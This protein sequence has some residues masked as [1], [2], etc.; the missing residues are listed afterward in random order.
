MTTVFIKFLTGVIC[1]G[2]LIAGTGALA[3]GTRTDVQGFVAERESATAFFDA[4]SSRLG[5]SVILSQKAARKKISG[6]FDLSQP[7]RMLEKI[8][9]QMAMIW[10]QDGQTV[11]I[12]D[13]TET[14]SQ[15][16][17]LT[18]TSVSEVRRFLKTSGLYDERYPLRAADSGLT[19]YV[20]GPPGYVEVV[21]RTAGDLDGRKSRSDA[22]LVVLPLYNTFVD[23]RD[24]N[25]RDTRV[26][27]PGMA[28]V[29]SQLSGAAYKGVS[30]VKSMQ[31][32]ADDQAPPAD[33]G[34]IRKMPVPGDIAATG[35][36]PDGTFVVAAD[37]A[38]N[39]LIVRGDALQIRTVRQLVAALDI[40]RRHVE[41]SVWIVD[42]KKSEIDQLGVNWSG[43]LSVGN[44]FGMVLNQGLE[45]TVDGASF[46]ASVQALAQEH[47]ARIVSR[48]VILTQENV[49]AIFDNNRTFYTRLIGER[50]VQLEQVTWGTMVNVLPRFT[51]SAEIELM[52]SVEDGSQDDKPVVDGLPEV[53]RTLISTVARVPQGKSLLVG[54]YTR[55]EETNRVSG[56]PGLSSIPW[57]GGLFR[58]QQDKTEDVVR[59]FLI[60]PREITGGDMDGNTMKEKLHSSEKTEQ[61]VDWFQN[62]MSSR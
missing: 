17:S 24:M 36:R 22:E 51:E 45:S 19:F 56:I 61:L 10:Y 54:G 38:S 40:P 48:P 33:E 23:D 25:F 34:R 37:P 6:R 28:S 1:T 26:V 21:L 35:R 55:R 20:S 11:W 4:L 53:G 29:V 46:I 39:A 47:K 5:K 60:Q 62:L 15:I 30:E 32:M 13:A 57:V 52:L 3:E 9:Q 7:E 18:Q 49:P 41:L 42:L 16:V 50:S 14:I 31:P 58:S 12:Y 27:I 2:L 44:R 43:E 8:T 59:L